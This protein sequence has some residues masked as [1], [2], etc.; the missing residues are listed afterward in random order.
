MSFMKKIEIRTKVSVRCDD[1]YS[2]KQKGCNIL[3]KKLHA[4]RTQGG[5]ETMAFQGRD[6]E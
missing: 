6:G 1:I 5:T 2:V 4:L 3:Q